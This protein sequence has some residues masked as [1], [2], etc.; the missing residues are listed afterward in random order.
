MTTKTDDLFA[1]HR[2]DLEAVN[3]GTWV[4]VHGDRFLIA[5]IHAD[6]VTTLRK[7]F[8]AEHGLAPDADIPSHLVKSWMTHLFS[9]GILLDSKFASQPD[10]PHDIQ[11]G[12]LIYTQPSLRD[13]KDR[14][15]GVATGDYREVTLR[16]QA[17]AG[18]SSQSSNGSATSGTSQTRSDSPPQDSPAK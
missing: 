18:N 2:L 16:E 10:K 5:S 12:E 8:L 13:L 1:A 15:W 7:D 3:K 6:H 11:T 17:V 9:R 4:D 14:L